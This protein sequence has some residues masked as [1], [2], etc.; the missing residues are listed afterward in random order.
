MLQCSLKGQMADE[1]TW[2]QKLSF[3]CKNSLHFSP[4]RLGVFNRVGPGALAPQTEGMSVG[5]RKGNKKKDRQLFPS[6]FYDIKKI[7]RSGRKHI[8]GAQGWRARIRSWG[9][10]SEQ[11]SHSLRRVKSHRLWLREGRIPFKFRFGAFFTPISRT[12]NPLPRLDQKRCLA[13]WTNP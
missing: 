3:R 13:S 6:Q 4:S 8:Q 5:S 2:L 7:S 10:R 11:V 12:T 9:R 1:R